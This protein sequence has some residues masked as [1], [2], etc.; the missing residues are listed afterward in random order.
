MKS[1]TDGWLTSLPT[2]RWWLFWSFQLY[3]D[4]AQGRCALLKE[5]LNVIALEVELVIRAVTEKT[6]KGIEELHVGSDSVKLSKHLLVDVLVREL[7]FFPPCTMN[8]T[9]EETGNYSNWNELMSLW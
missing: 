2:N 4:L 6:N 3:D 8:A 9:K 7:M 5:N 1:L